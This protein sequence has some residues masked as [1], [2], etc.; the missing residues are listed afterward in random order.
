MQ[1]HHLEKSWQQLLDNYDTIRA[2]R[3]EK[4]AKPFEIKYRFNHSS[5]KTLLYKNLENYVNTVPSS[6]ILEAI[7]ENE[8]INPATTLLQI[9][10]PPD[11]THVSAGAELVLSR[12]PRPRAFSANPSSSKEKKHSPVIN[13]GVASFASASRKGVPLSLVLPPSLP[14]PCANDELVPDLPPAKPSVSAWQVAIE[15]VTAEPT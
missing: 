6:K 4:Q 13:P 14:L 11:E 15:R 8:R 3:Q 12:T 5:F 10:T 9:S 7:Y 2:Y 1:H